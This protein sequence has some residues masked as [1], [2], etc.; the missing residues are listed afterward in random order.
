MPDPSPGDGTPDASERPRGPRTT[1]QPGTL[2]RLVAEFVVI[3]V[4]VLVALAVDDWRAEV[5]SRQRALRLI[6]TMEADIAASVADLREAAASAGVRRDALAELIR[7]AGDPPPPE[8]SWRPWDPATAR[9]IGGVAG[10]M[11]EG[12]DLLWVMPLY[13]QVFDPRTASFDELRSTGGL[14]SIPDPGV[15]RE[16]VEFFG[17]ILD[18]AESN[19]FMRTDQFALQESWQEAGII[20]SDWLDREEF[21]SR[22]RASAAAR[23]A[24]RRNFVRAEEQSQAYPL[25]A[26]SLSAQGERLVRRARASL[27]R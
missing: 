13:V 21:L 27:E 1:F 5:E 20:A 24:L 9:G 15:Q 2:R 17:W 14:A 25:V 23:A 8:G 22:L 26:D 12:D 11:P 6:S 3:V 10:L 4:G 18:F 16:I 7:L 19:Q